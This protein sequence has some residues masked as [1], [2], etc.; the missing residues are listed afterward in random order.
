MNSI[1]K[2][3][4]FDTNNVNYLY[5][6]AYI[7]ELIGNTREALKTYQ[8]IVKIRKNYAAAN[9]RAAIVYLINF[10]DDIS[11]ES[12]AFNYLALVPDD[13]SGYELLGKI[14]KTRA[15][16]YIDSNTVTLLKE[17]LNLQ[18]NFKILI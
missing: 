7:N 4:S 10:K 8:N 15:E 16:K 6:K 17:A 3:I 5:E 13:Y 2:A 11:A 18:N 14:Y 1:N 12:Y 9:Y